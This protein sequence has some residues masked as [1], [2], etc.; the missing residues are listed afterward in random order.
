MSR[1]NYDKPFYVDVGTSIAAIECASN[2]DVVDWMDHHGQKEIIK[3]IEDKCD[4]LNQEAKQFYAPTGNAAAMR[5]ALME[6]KG[7]FRDIDLTNDT[8]ENKAYAIAV[9]ALSAPPRNCD[10]GTAEEQARR[11]G[12]MCNKYYNDEDKC[13]E[14]CPLASMNFIQGFPRCQAYWEQMPYEADA[15]KGAGK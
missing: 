6:I 3:I 9:S 5:E 7:L 4:R 10:V 1:S 13:D 14:R 8:P 12:A 15:E 2:G 11:F